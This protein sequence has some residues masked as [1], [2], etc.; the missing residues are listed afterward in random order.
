MD[1]I[2]HNRRTGETP[3][4]T[5]AAPGSRAA[6]RAAARVNR[7]IDKATARCEKRQE[8]ATSAPV[9][10]QTDIGSTPGHGVEEKERRDRAREKFRAWNADQKS[11]YAVA[12]LKG[13]VKVC[14]TIPMSPLGTVGLGLTP[15]GG[16]QVMGLNRCASR[17][18][19]RCWN[20][21]AEKRAA[22]LETAAKWALTSGYT[23]GMFT[24]TAA[25]ATRETLMAAGGS[26]V[27]AAVAQDVKDL[28]ERLRAAWKKMHEGRGGQRLTGPRIGYARAAEFTLDNLYAYAV[29]SGVHMHFHVLIILESTPGQE[30]AETVEKY[31]EN[32]YRAWSRACDRQDLDTSREGFDAMT[33]TSAKEVA[34]YLAKTESYREAAD[35]NAAKIALEMTN[36]GVKQ[37]R[38]NRRCS[39]EELLRN[40][41]RAR[42]EGNSRMVS[43]LVA[44]WREF[45]EA[46]AGLNWLTWSRDLRKLAGV[47]EEM[48]AEEAAAQEEATTNGQVAEVMYSE[49]AP[50]VEVIREVVRQA[51]EPEKWST[52]L[53]A[54]DSLEVRY[55]VTSEAEWRWRAGE[56]TWSRNRRRGTAA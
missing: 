56:A 22:D 9:Q 43:R 54:L 6:R 47:G 12:G 40:I 46:A 8:Q 15:S 10:R 25:H 26:K 39:P 45:E 16:M 3:A 42:V 13:R 24:L 2:Q 35:D 44:Q 41:A 53:L 33:V 19:A 50:H 5:P 32:L 55:R 4:P 31:G 21:V 14:S 51:P 7:R 30:H 11:G 1:T 36:T 17:W 20:K 48:T 29:P 38:G 28:I 49:V 34:G 18:C 23:V 27:E 52:L 37:A